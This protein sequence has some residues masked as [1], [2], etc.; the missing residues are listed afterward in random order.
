MLREL[1]I[2]N[3]AVIQDVNLELSGGLNCFTGQTGAGKSLILGAFEMLLGLRPA[4]KD[5]LR[6]GSKE[7][8]ITGLFELHDEEV[9]TEVATILDQEI[10]VGDQL[11]LVRKITPSRSSVAINGQ[12]VTAAMVKT[13]GQQLVDIHGQHDHQY[14]LRA[15]NQLLIL[16]RFA[17]CADLRKQYTH[18]WQTLSELT[19]RREELTQSSTLRTQ[20]LDL[21]EFQAN[22]IDDAQLQ[23]GEFEELS[24]R[25]KWLTNVHKIQRDSGQAYQAL[26]DSD[27][28]V[29]E[30]LQMIVHLLGELEELD[31]ELAEPT[32]AIREATLALQEGAF[33]LGRYMDRIDANPHELDEVE[34][35]LNIINRLT[36]KYARNQTGVDPVEEILTYR[37]QIQ[38]EI[39]SLRGKD[40]DLS[41]LDKQIKQARNDLAK[42]GEKLSKK[43]QTAAKKIKPLIETQ[44]DELGM[45]DAQFHVEFSAVGDEGSMH[46]LESLEFMIRTNPGQPA[47]P[48][49]KIASG[50]ELSRIMLALKSILADS[51]RISVLVFDEIDANIGGRMGT[52]IGEK[53]RSLANSSDDGS[54]QILCITHL[55]Q[56]A[57]YADRHLHI[58]KQVMGKGK[59]RQ[60]Q[61]TVLHLEGDNRVNELAEMLAG[62]D[63]TDTTRKQIQEMLAGAS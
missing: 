52:I 31:E 20:Q 47:R 5:M 51:D 7:A 59:D 63:A 50:G 34:D 15:S 49:R 23:T 3:L 45:A 19:Q 17:E 62:K 30:R 25:H 35:R 9:V 36:S 6:P 38:T 60:T 33:D 27:A 12:P 28:S 10:A 32:Q 21:Y 54:H 44:L 53:L 8:R 24:A 40:A 2:S 56:I 39:E 11:L 42:H 22:E 57:A 18:T 37:E 58:T 48:M 55:P 14:L 43:R 41:S 46:G 13:V 16:D 29:I 61:T 26:Y 1:H 4:G